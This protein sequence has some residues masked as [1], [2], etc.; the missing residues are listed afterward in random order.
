MGEVGEFST[1][2]YIIVFIYLAGMF[3]VGLKLAG[4]QKDTED[5]FLAGRNMPWIVVAMS[6][7][8]SMT[9]AISYIGAPGLVYAENAAIIVGGFVSVAVA[10]LLIYLFYPF[11]RKLNVTTSYEYIHVRYGSAARYAVSGLFLLTRLGWLGT[12]IYAPALALHVVT[13][14]N[15]WLALFL[16]GVLATAYTTLGGLSA[17]L[18]TDMLQFTILV[19]GAIW[20]CVTLFS[21]VP[22]SIG[23]ILDVAHQTDHI[24]AFDWRL[25]LFKM[26]GMLM[27]INYFFSFVSD[28]GIDQVTVQRL[29]AIKDYWG[30]VRAAIT[31]SF[32]DLFNMAMFVFIG[33]GLFA[34]YQSFPEQLG[35]GI[36]GDKVFPYFIIQ[37]LPNG[38]SG[39]L[40]TAI[41]AAAMSSMDSGINS[42]ATVIVNDFVRPLRQRVASDQEDLRLARILTLVLGAVA[43]GVACYVTTVAGVLE[44]CARFAGFFGG[45]VIAM[46]L[47]GV[48]S[49]RMNFT[50]WLTGAIVSVG[51]QVWL[52]NF[53]EVHFY[54]YTLAS[55]G[56][57]GIVGYGASIFFGMLLK[58]P[59]GDRE[60]TLM[61][62][63][64]LSLI[65]AAPTE[66]DKQ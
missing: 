25:N 52:Q 36:E 14:V 4:K 40:V 57:S 38:V 19:G 22:G 45:P 63:G 8:A 20:V 48:L 64:P 44:A 49:R 1:L 26:T 65:T 30:M 43:I 3:A 51:F 55:I 9:S 16:M 61:G 7:F 66:E 34:Y 11:Y 39:L 50:G 15:L 33:L 28:Y 41:F 46:F 62:R 23:N 6:M 42:M 10:P 2:N 29:M 13:G 35:A 54:Y 27:A 58:L 5:F 18:W 31:N 32:F 12:V 24:G 47:L 21:V 60:Y 17:V 59:L 37:V 53:T 56:V